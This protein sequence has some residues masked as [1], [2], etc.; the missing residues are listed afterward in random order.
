MNWLK[1]VFGSS[2]RITVRNPLVIQSPKIGFLNLVGESGQSLLEDDKAALAPIFASCVFSSDAVPECDVLLIYAQVQTDGRLMGCS[3][4]LRDIIRKAKA[5]IAI[6]AF[7]NE[8]SSLIAAGKPTGYG[9][10]NLVLTINRKGAAFRTFY[11]ELFGRMYRGKSMPVAWVELAPQD[12]GA[13]HENCPDGIF[14]A[15]ISHVLF[16]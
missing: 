8:P 1:R 5:V 12:P 2:N 13:T 14:S 15:E 10:A 7:P 11:S 4:G 9:Q 16:R 3:D 6:V